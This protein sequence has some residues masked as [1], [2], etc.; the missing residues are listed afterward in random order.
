MPFGDELG[1]EG[2]WG[3]AG[4]ESTQCLCVLEKASSTMAPLHLGGWERRG[5]EEETGENPKKGGQDTNQSCPPFTAQGIQIRNQLF[6]LMVC[7]PRERDPH[8]SVST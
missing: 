5:E 6:Q 3:Q 4:E 7:G 2:L 8:I 1:R